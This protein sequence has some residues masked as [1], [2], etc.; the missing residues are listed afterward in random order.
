M[1]TSVISGKILDPAGTALANVKV[2]VRLFPVPAFR[3]SDN[4]ELSAQKETL[5]AS[6]GSY[7]F[8]LERT[9]GI[10]P[11]G[12]YYI[13]TEYLPQQ[14]G[15]AIKHLI[16]VGAVAATVQA[17]LLVTPPAPTQSV[18][19]TQTTGDARYVLAPAS[20][21]GAANIT[22][23]LPDD[24]ADAGVLAAYSRIDHRHAIVA[25][26]PGNIAVYDTATEGVATS[27]AR[28]DHR[29]SFTSLLALTG[30]LVITGSP[31]ADAT[32]NVIIGP[33]GTG[34]EGGQITLKGGLNGAGTDWADWQIDLFQD[35]IRFHSGG[36][37]YFQYDISTTIFY[38][39]G[40]F[41]AA[42]AFFP[43]N[44]LTA[45]LSLAST[46]VAQP[47]ASGAPMLVGDTGWAFYHNGLGSHRMGFRGTATPFA[48]RYGWV[49]DS[50]LVGSQPSDGA[51]VATLS[52]VGGASITGAVA[53][54]SSLVAAIQ[55]NSTY[56]T[57]SSGV[58]NNA[59]MVMNAGAG[60]VAVA[61]HPGGVAPQLRVGNGVDNGFWR[62]SADSAYSTFTGILVNTS[63]A[64]EKQDIET[65]PPVPAARGLLARSTPTPALDKVLAIRPTTFRRNYE[66]FLRQVVPAGEDADG[67]MQY[68][69][70]LHD[71][72]R[73]CPD[74]PEGEV[75][76]R[77]KNWQH[78]ELGLI[79]E[80]VYD[81][82]PEAVALDADGKP[83]GLNGVAMSAIAI[84]AIKELAQQVEELR[85]RLK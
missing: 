66:A 42:G 39:A 56:N 64:A 33:I 35:Q 68:T 74:I 5:T 53:V 44:Q 50:F 9:S 29:H 28:S 24:A 47:F 79:A 32:T 18:F 43:L 19:L 41:Q 48:T 31:A 14:Y 15:G 12:S 27:F 58:W 40:S 6:D 2:T 49:A 71:C 38:T 52:V 20:F 30:G 36:I 3:T 37:P 61:W 63:S 73:D 67:V 25:A 75:C 83:L 34:D 16:Q 11:A 4:A 10:T 54:G 76:Q 51:V 60:N 46:Q 69:D 59:N 45:G 80:E 17:S 21:G 70:E 77:V 8:T 78:G 84:A 57:I 72:R 26:A 82:I 22:T 23:I 81:V 7:S 13:I 65:W 85:G 55:V 62:N 1:A